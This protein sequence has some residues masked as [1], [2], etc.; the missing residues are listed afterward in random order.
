[1]GEY[2][3]SIGSRLDKLEQELEQF[4]RPNQ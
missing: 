1:M 2:M 4:K 3:S